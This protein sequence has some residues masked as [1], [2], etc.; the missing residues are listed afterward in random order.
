MTMIDFLDFHGGLLLKTPPVSERRSLFKCSQ[1]QKRHIP[2]ATPK[3]GA[4]DC[5]RVTPNLL[6]LPLDFLKNGDIL[7]TESEI[8]SLTRSCIMRLSHRCIISLSFLLRRFT[9]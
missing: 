5:Q 8:R 1:K 4:E 2:A 6:I 7:Y 3:R 9:S